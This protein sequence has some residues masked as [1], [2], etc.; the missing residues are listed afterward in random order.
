ERRGSPL[1]IEVHALGAV[2]TGRLA[3][4]SWRGAD[5]ASWDFYAAK[6]LLGA[7]LDTL[8]VDWDAREGAHPFL[9]PGRS[10]RV[11][12][13]ETELG[14]LGEVHPLV[15]REWDL[16]A[17]V[18]AFEIDLGLAIR[19]APEE[20][21]FTPFTTFPPALR[22]LAVLRPE[23]V[24]AARILAVAEQHADEA[25]VFDVYGD[26]LAMH[27]VFRAPD[28]TLTDDEVDE[29]MAAIVAALRE[30]GVERRA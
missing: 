2:L 17:A 8:R 27:L 26:S 23:G 30:L 3:P 18:A 24:S 9:H 22:D 29:R 14:W 19:H 12:S 7:V 21:P 10:A 15:A 5:A 13:G 6:A 11:Y 1:P 25:E 4:E 28:R 20:L 16:D